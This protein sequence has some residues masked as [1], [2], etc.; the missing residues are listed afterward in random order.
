MSSVSYFVKLKLH[1][2]MDLQR[3][4]TQYERLQLQ[5]L[6]GVVVGMLGMAGNEVIEFFDASKMW[7]LICSSLSL[8]GWVTFAVA[9]IRLTSFSKNKDNQMLTSAMDDERVQ[10]HRKDAFTFGFGVVLGWL[11]IV[12]I[13]APLLEK[14]AGY[15]MS[16]EFTANLSIALAIAASIGKFIYLERQ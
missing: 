4:E 2:D 15:V 8:I 1:I 10:Q 6:V 13:G 3:M 16:A 5:M 12:M 14:F 11:V 7:V 9:L